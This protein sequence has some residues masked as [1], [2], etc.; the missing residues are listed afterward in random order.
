MNHF[1]ILPTVNQNVY[2]S[3]RYG[4][5]CNLLYTTSHTTMWQ[6]VRLTTSTELFFSF[7]WFTCGLSP[8]NIL[9]R[10][11][12]TKRNL[13]NASGENIINM[14]P[15]FFTVNH[16]QHAQSA[17]SK[18]IHVYRNEVNFRFHTNNTTLSWSRLDKS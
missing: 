9:R 7:Y 12:K 2:S 8:R 10:G 1:I 13:T 16:D 11:S 5:Q 6:G 17:T 15:K 14:V 4:S 3:F 18:T